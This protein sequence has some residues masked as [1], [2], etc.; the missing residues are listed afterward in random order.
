[1]EAAEVLGL[2]L[3]KGMC[4]VSAL[5]DRDMYSPAPAAASESTN[6]VRVENHGAML[7][8]SIRIE[9]EA[10]F[11]GDY[12]ASAKVQRGMHHAAL[13]VSSEEMLQ[14][15]VIIQRLPTRQLSPPTSTG[16]RPPSTSS[17]YSCPP[18]TET[19]SSRKYKKPWTLRPPS[20]SDTPDRVRA[21]AKPSSS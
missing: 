6:L 20:C 15:H 21:S 11:L 2:G 13:L 10:V 17:P 9:L 12:F 5:R 1:M 3:R 18:A 7:H 4:A 8:A 14:W 19:P 16:C